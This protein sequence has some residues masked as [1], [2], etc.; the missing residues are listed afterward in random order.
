MIGN[1]VNCF[2]VGDIN[3]LWG[4]WLGN[5]DNLLIIYSYLVMKLSLYIEKTL[6]MVV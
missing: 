1:F 4:V 3:F 6:Y 2:G 5:G